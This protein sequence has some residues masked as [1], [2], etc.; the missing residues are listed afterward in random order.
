MLGINSP[1]VNF[2]SLIFFSVLFNVLITVL[3]IVFIDSL[4]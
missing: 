3:F 1:F 2:L 4:H